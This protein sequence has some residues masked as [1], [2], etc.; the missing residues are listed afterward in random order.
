[1]KCPLIVFLHISNTQQFDQET[2]KIYIYSIF[3]YICYLFS[4][5][6][7][8]GQFCL[9]FVNKLWNFIYN[10][11]DYDLLTH[12]RQTF[13]LRFHLKEKSIFVPNKLIKCYS[14]C[15]TL[16]HIQQICNKR[17]SKHLGKTME[18]LYEWKFNHCKE[19][20][21][22]WQKEKLLIMNNFSFCHHVFIFRMLQMR[23]IRVKMSTSRVWTFCYIY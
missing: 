8:D 7:H 10:I 14:S 21:I 20:Q 11:V 16:P 19:M 15:L 6:L 3:M 4:L 5:Y 9:L 22:W 1:M 12:S 23:L 18:I 13:I 17:I 2:G